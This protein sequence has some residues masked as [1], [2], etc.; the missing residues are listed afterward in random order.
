MP[1]SIHRL[2]SQIA[3][4]G[5]LAMLVTL[6]TGRER[7]LAGQQTA[8]QNDATAAHADLTFTRDIAPR[9]DTSPRVGTRGSP[10]CVRRSG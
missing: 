10:R 9:W 1:V 2:V 3:V 7:A 8:A 4:A 5:L 6:G